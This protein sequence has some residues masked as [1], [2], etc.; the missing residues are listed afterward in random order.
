VIFGEPD[1]V[2]STVRL[3]TENGIMPVV[4]ATGGKC[5]SLSNLLIEE[6]QKAS[7]YAFVEKFK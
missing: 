3:C 4:V 6:I 7:D 2:Y 1:F 5:S